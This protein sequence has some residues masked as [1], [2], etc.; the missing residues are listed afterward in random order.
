MRTYDIVVR[1]VYRDTLYIEADSPEEAIEK[2]E[3]M[4]NDSE[5]EEGDLTYESTLP[6][7]EWMVFDNQQVVL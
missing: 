6:S 1:S 3:A 4:V 7:D 2:A 5:Y